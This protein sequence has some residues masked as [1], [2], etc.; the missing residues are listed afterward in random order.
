MEFIKFKAERTYIPEGTS[1]KLRWVAR[2]FE[3]Q[4]LNESGEVVDWE[5]AGFWHQEYMARDAIDRYSH[6]IIAVHRDDIKGWVCQGCSRYWG[7]NERMA[8]YCCTNRNLCECGD[9]TDRNYTHCNSCREKLRLEREQ[10]RVELATKMTVKEAS[11]L[12]G[13]F[14]DPDHYGFDGVFELVEQVYDVPEPE[15]PFPIYVWATKPQSFQLSL[16]HAIECAC[17]NHHEGMMDCLSGTDELQA[18]VD[19]FNEANKDQRSYDADYS[20]VCIVESLEQLKVM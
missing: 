17:D 19:L 13:V 7:K 20:R 5:L 15:I 8:R 4:Y 9:L 3:D 14:I 11:E 18:A 16:D 12:A 10:K 2:S 6:P 1:K